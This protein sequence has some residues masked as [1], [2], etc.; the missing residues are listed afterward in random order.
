[1]VYA[2]FPR[3]SLNAQ[4]AAYEA[5]HPSHRPGLAISARYLIAFCLISA[6]MWCLIFKAAFAVFAA[7][8]L[9]A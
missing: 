5:A 1:M 2:S 4:I 3:E 7:L 6:L 9:G 8:P